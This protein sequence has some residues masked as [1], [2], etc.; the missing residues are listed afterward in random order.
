MQ[1]TIYGRLCT[2]GQFRF[3]KSIRQK[4]DGLVLR[5]SCAVLCAI[6]F[7]HVQSGRL[8]W[9]D[10]KFLVRQRGTQ[11]SEFYWITYLATLRI[12]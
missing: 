6:D 9:N 10:D 11:C 4:I 3:E 8:L 2:R 5:R 12:N 1:C 7:D